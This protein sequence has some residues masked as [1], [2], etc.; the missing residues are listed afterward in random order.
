MFIRYVFKDNIC[1]FFFH[2]EPKLGDI[3]FIYVKKNEKKIELT[4]TYCSFLLPKNF[5]EEHINTDCMAL[6]SLLCIFPFIGKRVYFGFPVSVKVQQVIQELGITCLAIT[7]KTDNCYTTEPKIPGLVYSGG[8]Q[9]TASLL[10]LDKKAKVLFLNKIE[11]FEKTTKNSRRITNNDHIYYTL[12]HLIK[13]EYDVCVVRSDIH[14]MCSPPCIPFE[15]AIGTHAILLSNYFKLDSIHYGFTRH[16]IQQLLKPIPFL[17]TGEWKFTF[18]EFKPKNLNKKFLSYEKWNNLFKS[19]NLHL[20][21][22]VMG[23]TPILNYRLIHNS[24][25]SID[26]Q[27]CEYGLVQKQCSKCIKCFVQSLLNHLKETKIIEACTLDELYSIMKTILKLPNTPSTT[28]SKLYQIPEL[29][30]FILYIAF[31]YDG[32][33]PIINGW[34]DKF[35]DY[36]KF[37]PKITQWNMNSLQYIHPNYR[38]LV[39]KNI[40]FYS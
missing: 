33:D 12:E 27:S 22:P 30:V 29:E 36:K 9:S 39:K 37:V 38:S 10:L 17:C 13:N 34:K 18:G 31:L 8:I 2:L 40:I 21:L 16:H 28:V 1:K 35:K 15:L 14:R 20:S 4:Q 7:N 23:C 19:C 11:P 24:N 6:L 5:S 32:R 26:I 25:L 3:K